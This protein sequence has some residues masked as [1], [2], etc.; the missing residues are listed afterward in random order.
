MKQ[1][2]T[3][4]LIIV[5]ITAALVFLIPAGTTAQQS[6]ADETAEK[7]H[8]FTLDLEIRPRFELRNGFK[9]PMGESATP[10]AFTEQRSRAYLGYQTSDMELKLTVQDVR[11]WGNQ[12][13]IFKSD[14]ALTNLYEAWALYRF[15]EIWAAKFG[16]QALNY[17]N[18][19]FL[20]N[21]DWAQQG[22][23]HDAFLFQYRNGTL[24]A[25]AGFT[26][27]QAD[28]FEPTNL[29]GTFYPLTGN[30][31]SMQYLWLSKQVEDSHLSILFH[32]DGRQ[33]DQD[34]V[35]WRQTAGIN[36]SR[37][38]DELSL[39]GE[40]YYQFGEDLAGRDVTAYLVNAELAFRTSGWNFTAGGD[41]LSGTELN[42]N[43]NHSFQPLY[44]T[45]HKFYG[46]M[47]YFHVGNPHAQP[48]NNLNAG[49]INPYQKVQTVLGDNLNLNLHLHQFI[50]PTDIFDGQGEQM[51]SYL[52]T[53][54]DLVLNWHP[55][56]S[57]TFIL[58]YSHMIA[59][60]TMIRIKGDGNLNTNN[61]WAWAMFRIHPSVLRL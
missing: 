9:S 13:Q 59:T 53:E 12:N 58:G 46:F 44:G 37:S 61:N 6:A 47:D 8:R 1:E 43:D 33:Q 36:G 26:F 41:W 2:F 23:S 27:N 11:I 34:N 51:D 20:G 19:R 16:R 35:V 42:E 55:S 38:L 52:G 7:E 48:G 57:A 30:N 54:L 40:F 15:D 5:C 21:L 25:D 29:T 18:A 17:D 22:R 39:R 56:P 60:D 49:L 4:L 28:V 32:N 31:K 24:K 10:A 3:S 45:N 50:S 14:P